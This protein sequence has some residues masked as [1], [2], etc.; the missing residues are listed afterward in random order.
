MWPACESKMAA[1]L[2]FEEATPIKR[3]IECLDIKIDCR[4]GLEA[5]LLVLSIGPYIVAILRIQ[6]GRH[7][8][9]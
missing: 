1:M 7:P 8:V 4:S 2:Y 6:D 3:W 5:E 9:L